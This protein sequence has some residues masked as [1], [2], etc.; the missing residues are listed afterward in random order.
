MIIVSD[1]ENGSRNHCL[2]EAMDGEGEFEVVAAEYLTKTVVPVKQVLF[3][4]SV[5]QNIRQ[6]EIFRRRWNSSR[7][8]ECLVAA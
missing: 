8:C 5:S 2:Q 1:L 7:I 4:L 3:G 6:K